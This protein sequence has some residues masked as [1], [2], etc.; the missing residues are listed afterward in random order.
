MLRLGFGIS[1]AQRAIALFTQ[2]D[3]AQLK[4]QHAIQHTEDQLIQ[5]SQEAAAQLK[6]LFEADTT[7]FARAGVKPAAA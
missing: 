4:I 6:E 7:S 2:N 1:E 3:E 5:T